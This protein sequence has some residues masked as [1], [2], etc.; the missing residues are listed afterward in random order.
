MKVC[1][2]FVI[3]I[4]FI[5]R[6]SL[7]IEFPDKLKIYFTSDNFFSVINKIN[8]DKS[9]IIHKDN[10]SYMNIAILYEENQKQF[11]KKGK[12]RIAGQYKDHVV[13]FHSTLKINILKDHINNYQT[14]RLLLPNTRRGSN[15]IFFS[16]IMEDFGFLT[17]Y[18]EIV[19]IVIND[20]ISYKAIFQEEIDSLFLE[21]NNF[22]DSPIL[23]IDQRQIFH[24][25]Y[26]SGDEQYCL[27]KSDCFGTADPNILFPAIK[28]SNFLKNEKSIEIFFNSISN[29]FVK[30]TFDI[31]NDSIKF[32][33]RLLS[34]YANHALNKHNFKIL[35]DPI[36]NRYLPI[37]DDG[38][39]KLLKFCSDEKIYEKDID[40]LI[41]NKFMHKKNLN[42]ESLKS[43]ILI[44]KNTFEKRSKEL[45]SYN[46]LCNLLFIYDISYEYDLK[47]PM[48][49]GLTN[50]Y[51]EK[52]YDLNN[53]SNTYEPLFTKKI[54]RNLIDYIV[55]DE[56]KN[57]KKCE[58]INNC[59]IIKNNEIKKNLSGNSDP[60]IFE[61]YYI[62]PVILSIR[63]N[64][65]NKRDE[66]H[67]KRIVLKSFVDEI[68]V[69]KNT[70]L[71]LKLD[72]YS[73]ELLI[74][75]V[76][77][78]TSKLIIYDSVLDN[79]FSLKVKSSLTIDEENEIFYQYNN[80]LLTGCV[81]IIDSVI[82][83]SNFYI[84]NSKC[85]D[86][87]NFI[88]SKGSIENIT[89]NNSYQDGIDFDFSNLKIK[90]IEI[91]N[92]GNDCLDFSKGNYEILNISVKTCKD[93][94]VSIGEKS[95]VLI[96][97]VNI[98]DTKYGLAVK[99]SSKLYV[100]EFI[101]NNSETCIAAYRKKEH[102]YGG[103][104]LINKKNNINCNIYLDKFSKYK[105][106]EE[107]LT[108]YNLK[109]I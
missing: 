10:K 101:S 86:S 100:N 102:F 99:D 53:L 23:K 91:N 65:S 15:E 27:N 95:N 66:V 62:Y 89:V 55:F 46:Q 107:I 81:T 6:S 38:D 7:A 80:R 73:H 50:P 41:K 9:R 29:D 104:I 105:N 11:Y 22:R 56:N 72:N 96:K 14:F 26:F 40:K 51:F 2:Y 28:N 92:A 108:L 70:N 43:K 82:L 98:N 71:Y 18:R 58:S 19:E 37:Y 36:Y 5:S 84:Q 74:N 63:N 31:N 32:Y 77:P 78:Q 3:F 90:N 57:L 83:N 8:N 24:N 97:N 94:G 35:F 45:L 52:N 48:D 17:P 61:N 76:D 16:M 49:E 4:F 54:D 60:K 34:T 39:V 42:Y 1:F 13:D 103:S 30:N 25:R 75:L 47:I 59:K 88:R 12:A 109:N 21:K 93:K 106:V 33:K 67:N 20:Q 64:Q 68:K 79:N 69:E 85:E 44:F 87:I